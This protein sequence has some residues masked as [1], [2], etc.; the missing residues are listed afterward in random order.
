[1][2]RTTLA[3]LAATATLAAPAAAATLADHYS[4]F[5]V[6]GDSLSDNGN[7]ATSVIPGFP[8]APYFQ[9]R[10]SDGPVWN[11]GFLAE[12]APGTAANFAFGAARAAPNADGIPDFA[13]QVALFQAV[14]PV[15]DLGA[16]PLASVLFG[17]NDVFGGIAAAAL[18]PGNAQTILGA[19]ITASVT[20]IA[21]GIGTLAAAGITDFAVFD[22]PDLG[23]TPRLAAAG[24]QAQGLGTLATLSFN[25]ALDQAVG[26]LRA[27]GVTVTQVSLFDLFTAAVADPAAFGFDPATVLSPCYGVDPFDL[28]AGPSAAPV[29]GD[30]QA[31]LFWD[32]LHPGASGHAAIAQTF[33]A[34][35]VPLPATSILLI[36]GLAGLALVR[37][38][39]PASA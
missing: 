29:C 5:W 16:R 33:E 24:P 25:A 31:R 28:L 19:A 9:G 6:F 23:L 2:I 36:G 37:R 30:P 1:M 7:L 8:P 26:G 3:A 34:A 14:R 27:S 11:E 22:L 17:A 21:T 39:R 4:S 32:V 15:I 12:F 38:R 35:V 18:D 20:A 13:D 10:F